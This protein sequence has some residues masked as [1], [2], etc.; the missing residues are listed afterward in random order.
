MDLLLILRDARASSVIGT[1]Q[2]AL[3]ARRDGSEVGV[4]VTQDALAAVARGSFDWPRELSGPEVRLG[5]AS[6]AAALGIPV[7]GRG[8]GRQLDPRAMIQL[9]SEAGVR[10]WACPVWSALLGIGE[11]LPEGL[12]AVE[13]G[14]PEL[15]RS[16]SRVVGA[17]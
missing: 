3:S 16:A 13:G 10:L 11:S 1:M 15:I 12:G 9:A 7:R 5:L 2:V 17:F 14:I 4:L 8:E 6:R